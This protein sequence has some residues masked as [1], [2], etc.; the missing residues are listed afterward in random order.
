MK[1]EIFSVYDTAASLY[2]DPF[3]AVTVE[4]AL[5]G[6]KTACEKEGHH[7][8]QWPE[9]YSLFHVGTFDQK[10]GAMKRFT[11][12]RLIAIG[13]QFAEQT[14]IPGI[15]EGLRR[16]QPIQQEEGYAE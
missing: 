1:Q 12:P 16:A 5:R 2:N 9:D 11:E 14:S 4:L 10:T 13:T 3:A 15:E 8:N 7:F 6:F